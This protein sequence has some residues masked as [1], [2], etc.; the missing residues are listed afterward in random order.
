[1]ENT[2]TEQKSLKNITT[3]ENITI[4]GKT[5]MEKITTKITAT[6]LLFF[7]ALFSLTTCLTAQAQES[8]QARKQGWFVGVSPFSFIGTE[9]KTSRTTTTL[10][11]TSAG[12]ASFDYEAIIGPGFAQ[13][14]NSSAGFMDGAVTNDEAKLSLIRGA[15]ALC[16]QGAATMDRIV[17]TV[18]LD[19]N[20]PVNNPNINT[21]DYYIGYYGGRLTD[22]DSGKTTKICDLPASDPLPPVPD[23]TTTDSLS[24]ESAISLQGALAIQF[25]YNLEKYRVS[26]TSFSNKAGANRLTNNVLLADWF[27]APEFYAGLGI[28][29]AK[30]ETEIGSASQTAP[31]F[32]LGYARKIGNLQ[33]EAG[34][35][36]LN[37]SF[38]I[39]K[40]QT[41][42]SEPN[43]QTLPP[44]EAKEQTLGETDNTRN[45]ITGFRFT[46]GP[47]Q[48]YSSI[49]TVTRTPVA[50]TSVTTT[51]TTTTE[52]VELPSQQVIYLRL[53]YSF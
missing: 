10:V 38:S 19:P 9:I 23:G 40:Q 18:P 46:S 17:D 25:G 14:T 29:S 53:V 41:L 48:S 51:T 5:T 34:Y 1:M 42:I 2:T 16:R 4:I 21:R 52:K 39:Q 6:A 37:S 8:G 32:N 45:I 28:T 36:L 13:F 3:I 33:L 11:D 30:L 20:S 12:A 7:V 35:L 50:T 26:L 31:A 24:S 47:S 49:V 44:G 27:L 43:T 22:T 15:I